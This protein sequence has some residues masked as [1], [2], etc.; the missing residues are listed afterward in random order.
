MAISLYQSEQ[1]HV[2]TEEDSK[3]I[4]G[5]KVYKLTGNKG[6]STLSF[7]GL[8]IELDERLPEKTKALLRTK[9]MQA[10]V[11][12]KLVKMKMVSETEEGGMVAP[13]M[14]K[15]EVNEINS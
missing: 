15:A 8:N 14:Q 6:A 4:L 9:I 13:D 5:V 2:K 10:L 12:E 11:K 1:S 7:K 3:S